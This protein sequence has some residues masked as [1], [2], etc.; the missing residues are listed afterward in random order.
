MRIGIM[1]NLEIANIMETAA[2]LCDKLQ[3]AGIQATVMEE[4]DRQD[5][6]GIDMLISIGG[7]GTYLHT[8]RYAVK[9]QIPILGMNMGR[10]GFLTQ[11]DFDGMDQAVELLKNGNYTV[12]E[13]F[14][15]DIKVYRDGK[16]CFHD[17]AFNDLVVFRAYVRLLDLEIHVDQSFASTVY[18]DG[19]IVATPTGS[20]A[21][22]LS[23][24]GPIVEPESNVMLITPICP[25]SIS[26]RPMVVSGEKV[27]RVRIK[28]KSEVPALI[29]V[30]GGAALQIN[31]RDEVVV[32]KSSQTAKVVKLYQ[33]DFYKVLREKFS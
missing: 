23:A 29:T 21:Y 14:L 25:H 11:F 4:Q 6:S 7:D 19:L 10:L 9:Y 33:T 20:T 1:P 15:A 27:I 22:S 18:G 2:L 3:A 8:T 30:D 5:L 13:R 24:G 31:E 26:S 32:E 16:V 17:Y 12:E 28:P